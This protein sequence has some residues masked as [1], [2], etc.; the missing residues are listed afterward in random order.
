MTMWRVSGGLAHLAF[1][2]CLSVMVLSGCS[3]SSDAE[4]PAGPTLVQLT[5]GEAARVVIG[6]GDTTPTRFGLPWGDPVVVNGRLYL[7]D[8][9]WHRIVGYDTIPT[10]GG[11]AGSFVLGQVSLNAVAAPGTSAT[12]FRW[13]ASVAAGGGKL[14]LADK[15][16]GRVLV[17]NAVPTTTNVPA[18]V[19]VGKATMTDPVSTST[20]T[21]SSTDW[22]V[23]GVALAAGKLIVPDYQH[24]RVLIWSS[25]PTT[26]GAPADL[27]LGQTSFTACAANAGTTVGAATMTYPSG[28]WSDG[29]RLAVADYG[30]HRV[31]FWRTF[32]TA[33]GQPADFVL[34]QAGLGSAVLPVT[35]TSSNTHTPI[36]VASN[37]TQLAIADRLFNRVLVWNTFPAASGA[38]ADVVLGQATFDAT[39]AGSSASG[40]QEPGGLAF[41]GDLL[42]VG[43]HSNYRYLVFR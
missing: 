22:G 25:V 26:N 29:T 5:S 36:S 41:H 15:D 13:P 8:G 1:S 43:D 2:C 39:G 18:D 16:N 19:V 32:P 14:A 30:N 34:G 21:A 31:L 24:H 33:N 11:A 42:I 12:R 38:A 4:P 6:D 3:S 10:A 23:W 7:P 27:V 37:G 20:C 9:G 17:W 40:M 28:V 35:A